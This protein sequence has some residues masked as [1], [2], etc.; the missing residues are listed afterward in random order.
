[1]ESKHASQVSFW[2]PGCLRY[3][4]YSGGIYPRQSRVAQFILSIKISEKAPEGDQSKILAE[5]TMA[6]TIGQPF[7]FKSAGTAKA[8]SGDGELEIGMHVTGKLESTENGMVRL[9]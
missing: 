7:S 5:P 1:M 2:L 8:K 9:A 6:T 3:R 4:V